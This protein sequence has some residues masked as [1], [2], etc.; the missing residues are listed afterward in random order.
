M[1]GGGGDLVFGDDGNDRLFGEDGDDVLEGGTGDDMVVGGNGDDTFLASRGD[2]DDRYYGDNITGG[3]A[4][5][6]TLDMSTIMANVTAD[7][8]RGM[9]NRG[10][11]YSDE[12]GHD[13][14]WGVENIVT[15]AG[16]DVIIANAAVN[17][18][19]GGDGNDIFSFRSANDADGDTIDL[20]GMDANASAAGHQSFTLVTG[21]MTDRGQLMVTEET[22]ADGTYTVVEGNLSGGPDG[23]FKL[24]IK[25]QHD[26]TEADFIL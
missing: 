9:M 12:T 22:R 11:V 19:D 7:L 21:A 8:G 1:A 10:S 18:I 20:S 17:V 25:G 14:I 13:T 15:G 4:G 5:S 26:L 16:D 24:N 23:D 2:G 6:D 3:D